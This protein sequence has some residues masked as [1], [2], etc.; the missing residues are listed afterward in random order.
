MYIH[1]LETRR[2]LVYSLYKRTWDSENILIQS[3]VKSNFFMGTEMFKK[4]KSILF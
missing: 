3:I 2:K 4:W 1:I